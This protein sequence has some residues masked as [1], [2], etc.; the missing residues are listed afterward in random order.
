MNDHVPDDAN[1]LHLLSGAYAVDALDDLERARFEVHLRTCAD[2]RVEVAGLREAAAMLADTTAV[3]PPPE[4]RDLVLAGIETVRPLPPIVPDHDASR[5]AAPG[6]SRR[7]SRRRWL[8]LTAVAAAILLIL[9]VGA[10]WQ[11][12]DDGDGTSQQQLTAADRVLG[13]DDA[14]TVS[15]EVAGAETK[16]VRSKSEGRAV[17]VATG[18]PPAP[19]GKVYE[20]WLQDETGHLAPAGLMPKG[21]DHTLVLEGDATDAT[22]VGIT[23]EPAGGSDVPTDSPIAVFDFSEATT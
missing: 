3:A 19:S 6:A 14:E 4:L 11:P 23:I 5:G 20:L 12:W 8:P 9:G 18:M 2:C 17:L 13:A 22:G 15:L 16:V 10:V 7:S 1:D 21:S